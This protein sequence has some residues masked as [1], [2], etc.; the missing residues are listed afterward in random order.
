MLSVDSP[1]CQARCTGRAASNLGTRMRGAA[2]RFRA[3]PLLRRE[4]NLGGH[5]PEPPRMGL[6][7]SLPPSIR[8]DSRRLGL[9]IRPDGLRTRVASQHAGKLRWVG[10]PRALSSGIVRVTPEVADTLRRLAIPLPRAPPPSKRKSDTPPP[11]TSPPLPNPTRLTLFSR[12]GAPRLHRR[13]VYTRARRPPSLAR[14]TL[15]AFRV[16]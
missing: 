3:A 10:A 12:V 4:R 2:H 7:P 6:R 1:P 13:G 5:P 14:P 8:T 15:P 9:A 16:S 11:P